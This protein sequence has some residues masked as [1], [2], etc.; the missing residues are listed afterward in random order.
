MPG[1]ELLGLPDPPGPGEQTGGAA[2]EAEAD[3]EA[4]TEGDPA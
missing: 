2:D 3:A 4:T 1:T